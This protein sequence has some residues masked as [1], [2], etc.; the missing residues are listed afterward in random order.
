MLF[1]E[2][3]HW[4][5]TGNFRLDGQQAIPVVAR[6]Q[7]QFRPLSLVDYYYQLDDLRRVLGNS[8]LLCGKLLTPN[9]H[10]I[11]KEYMLLTSA[12]IVVFL[13]VAAPILKVVEA[14]WIIKAIR[15]AVIT[16]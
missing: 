5:T 2:A 14:E 6:E 8:R 3:S 7:Q 12:T 15:V 10:L 1:D 9:L 13:V 4:E 11:P 16:R